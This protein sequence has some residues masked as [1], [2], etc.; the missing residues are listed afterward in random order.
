MLE[1]GCDYERL[2]YFVIHKVLK[3]LGKVSATNDGLSYFVIHKVLKQLS[4]ATAYDK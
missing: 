1:V 4:V 2:S 3:L